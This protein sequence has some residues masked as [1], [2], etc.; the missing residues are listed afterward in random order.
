[1]IKKVEY[2]DKVLYHPEDKNDLRSF[3]SDIL[4][5]IPDKYIEK[6][7]I[8]SLYLVEQND[9]MECNIDNFTNTELLD[10]ISYR[11][12]NPYSIGEDIISVDFVNR[13]GKIVDRI[14]TIKFNNI[15]DELEKNI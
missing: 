9:L 11:G 12:L 14:G 8:D 10:E 7:A 4:E 3:Y 15:L 13:I 5:L 2:D 1:M 6:Y